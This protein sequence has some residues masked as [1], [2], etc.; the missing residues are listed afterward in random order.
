MTALYRVA[1]LYPGLADTVSALAA[2]IHERLWHEASLQVDEV[3]STVDDPTLLRTVWEEVL[4]PH[5]LRF[6][7]LRLA[8]L[9]GGIATRLPDPEE[10]QKLVDKAFHKV[11]KEDRDAMLYTKID[12][13]LFELWKDN[14]K[15]CR[16]MLEECKATMDAHMGV[17]NAVFSEYYRVQ[18]MYLK[19]A[20]KEAEFYQSCLLY[21]AYTDVELLTADQRREIAYDL[22]VAALLGEGIYNFGELLVQDIISSL[23]GT[24]AA[25]L[26]LVLTALNEGKISLY[27]ALTEEYQDQL[28][29]NVRLLENAS[30]IAEKAKIMALMELVFERDPSQAR[31][32]TFEEVAERVQIPVETV[33]FTA[34]KALA[35]GVVKGRINQ[36]NQ[37]LE[38]DWVQP[39]VLT[40]EQ[41]G[42]LERKFADWMS[43]VESTQLFLATETPEI[44]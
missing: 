10:G 20:H 13:A 37:T 29:S 27:D 40:R 39:R 19:W 42:V 6:N 1:E 43:K 28:L 16:D 12:L 21:L 18:S 11:E 31:V 3:I 14:G 9:V 44:L 24:E 35:S 8:Q 17:D 22:G 41:T 23:E 7:P 2:N 33:E 36:V 30:L 38:I 5:M 32:F 4:E 26:P 25:W 15:I 34:L